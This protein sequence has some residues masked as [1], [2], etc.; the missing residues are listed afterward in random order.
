MREG[1]DREGRHLYPAFPYDHFART[2]DEDLAALYAYMMTRRPVRAEAPK[3]DLVFPLNVRTLLAGWKLMFMERTRFQ[4][5]PAQSRQWNRGAYLAQGLGH[6]GSCHT[7][8]NFLGG[9][10]GSRPLAGGDAGGWHAPAL[11]SSNPAPAPWTQERLFAYLRHGMDDAHSVAAGPMAI[12]ARNLA[13]APEE[14][15]RAIATYIGTFLPAPNASAGGTTSQATRLGAGGGQTYAAACAGCHEPGRAQ[16]SALHLSLSTA[17][18]LPTPRNLIHIILGGITPPEGSR[19]PWMPSYAGALTDAQVA[20]LA[21]YLRQ[22][23]GRQPAWE[24][25]EDEVGKILRGD[26]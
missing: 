23:F 4:P 18:A 15:V 12:V 13:Q 26:S 5:D 20:E 22:E 8:R 21:N 19:G 10:K 25:V 17:V 24:N 7:P 11:N 2:S 1:V 3:P 14:D 16:G 6:C 9:E